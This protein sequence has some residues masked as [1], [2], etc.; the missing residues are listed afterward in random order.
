MFDMTEAFNQPLD[1]WNVSN[2]TNM[3][4]MFARSNFNQPI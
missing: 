3:C 1:T 4:R 2:V